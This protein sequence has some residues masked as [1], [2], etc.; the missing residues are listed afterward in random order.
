[1]SE[2]TVTF[3][4]LYNRSNVHLP[5]LQL[6]I[7]FSRFIFTQKHVS[8][9]Q[10][11]N[12]IAVILSDIVTQFSFSPWNL[13]KS[14]RCD[15]CWGLYRQRTRSVSQDL[16]TLWHHS[17]LW[18]EYCPLHSPYNDLIIIWLDVDWWCSPG[19]YQTTSSL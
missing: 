14:W 3:Y 10:W 1:M 12:Y 6:S 18:F 5:D 9:I 13:L 4:A 11:K 7:T 17:L 8:T 2:I 19:L 15:I 16:V